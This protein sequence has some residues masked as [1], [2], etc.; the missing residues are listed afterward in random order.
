[1]AN[2][3]S[4]QDNAAGNLTARA[5]REAFYAGVIALGLFVLFIGLKTDQNIHN[6]LVLV[7]RWGLLAIFVILA[8]IGRF[9]MVAYIQPMM[10]S[11]KAI[12]AAEGEADRHPV[13]VDAAG[14]LRHL[15]HGGQIRSNVEGVRH[16]KQCHDDAQH[17][18]W[19]RGADVGGEAFAG[20]PA[21]AGADQL[22]GRHERERQR[23]RPQHVEAILRARLRI[24]YDAAGV[25]VG[26]AGN[27]SRPNPGERM[28]PESFAQSLAQG[29]RPSIAQVD[30][31]V[32]V[33]RLV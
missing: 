16:E 17:G 4:N 1:M 18:G 12:Q 31:H 14:E 19:K 13:P 29:R 7:Q 25:V 32:R 15:A 28:L 5:F 24:G 23:H 2:T 3:M 20:D 22:D 9:V 8:M 33:C 26:H 30:S 10:A 27:Q 11:R 6:E 21:D